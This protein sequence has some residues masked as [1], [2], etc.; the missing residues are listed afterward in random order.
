MGET[1][2]TERKKK[3]LKALI[4]SYINDVEPISSAAIQKQY[5]PEV[6]TATIR[7]E[8]SMLEEM[9]YLTQPHVSSG[10]I[11]SSKAYKYYVEH[12]LDISDIDSAQIREIVN[13]KFQS[14]QEVV[15]NGAKIV[16]DITNYT[17]ML[18]I[19]SADNIVIKD[20][21]IID[22]YDNT[23]LVLIVT[24]NGVIKNKQIDLPHDVKENF[25]EV[26][27]GLLRKAFVGKSIA[28][29]TNGDDCLDKELEAFRS[30]Y[31][32]VIAFVM[33]FKNATEEQLYVEGTEK[34]FDYPEYKDVDNVRQFMSVVSHREK[35]CGLMEGEG[36]IEYC[37]RIGSED[38]VDLANMALI[39]AKYNINGKEVGHV[40]VIGPERMDYKKVLGVLKE[41]GVLLQDNKKE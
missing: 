1:N 11:P 5:L 4:D 23:A 21:K 6:S 8:L 29:V 10:R 37:V 27:G 9:G 25:I 38:S 22:M 40:G 12:I 15:K 3:I 39:T 34:I 14:V 2:L 24:D 7:S 19:T 17:S 32:Q 20:I 33:D 35:L 16:S 28:E 31:E 36:D 30:I 41:L 26:A 13:E 18:M